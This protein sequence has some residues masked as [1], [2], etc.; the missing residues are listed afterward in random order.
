MADSMDQSHL[1]QI[2]TNQHNALNQQ[3][4]C[5]SCGYCPT[6]GRKNEYNQWNPQYP[7]YGPYVTTTHQPGLKTWCGTQQQGTVSY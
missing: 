2:N 7:G 6:C 4:V 1:S 3:T 5:P